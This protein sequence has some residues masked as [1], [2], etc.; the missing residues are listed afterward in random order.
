VG[1]EIPVSAPLSPLAQKTAKPDEGSKVP[2]EGDIAGESPSWDSDRQ[3]Y[4]HL[5]K[6][7]AWIVNLNA[8]VTRFGNVQ[9]MATMGS[10]TLV[11]RDNRLVLTN[12]HVVRGDFQERLVFFPVHRNGAL[13]AEKEAYLD[14]ARRG[15]NTIR[16]KVLAQ[17]ERC[18]LA[19]IQ[20]DRLP[21]GIEAL[22]LA[23]S[24]VGPGQTVH[25]IGGNPL[26]GAGLWIYP[27]AR[28]GRFTTS[29]G[30]RPSM[31][32][33]AKG[34][35]Q[36]GQV[37]GVVIRAAAILGAI[38]AAPVIRAAAIRE[39]I[40]VAVAIRVVAAILRVIWAVAAIKAVAIQAA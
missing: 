35:R 38:R 5:L 14:E 39:A 11:D 37:A 7:V 32:P 2:P 12:D 13:L 17:E 19:L 34:H 8:T 29:A 6:S 15:G 16:Y 10:G 40:R 20:L 22:A 23:K 21:D 30:A 26:G 25:S 27:S 33:L 36:G 4:Q 28:S 24:S 1:R 3:V 31:L 9:G 18:D